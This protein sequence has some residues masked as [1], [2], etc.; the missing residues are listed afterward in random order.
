VDLRRL[1]AIARRSFLFVAA[2][3]LIAGGAAFLF[4]TTLTRVYEANTTLIVGQSLSTVSPDYNQLLVSQ[5]LSTTYASL[6]TTRPNLEAVITKLGLDE[7]TDQLGRSVNAEASL[8]ST[9][10]KIT[11]QDSDPARAA[12]VANALAQQLVTASPAVQGREA[13]FQASIEA[14]LKAT[15]DQID[16]TESQVA[17]L[18]S[19]TER[20]AAQEADLRGLESGL[21]SLRSTYAT[22]LSYASSNASNLLSVVEPAV[23]P[24]APVSPR[25]LLN[26]LLAA[27][28]GLFVGIIVIAVREYLDDSIKTPEDVLESAGLATLGQIMRMS[29]DRGRNGKDRV[30]ALLH[31]RSAVTESY[32]TLRANIEFASF[33]A[34]LNTLLI[35]SSSPLEGKTVTAANLAVVFAQ[36]GR[37]VLLVDADLRKPGVHLLFDLPNSHGLTTLLRTDRVDLHAVE[38]ATEQENLRILTTGPLP[39]NPVELLGSQRMRAILD[40]MKTAH[41]LVLFD[42]PPLQI[43]TDTAI[44][45]SIADGTVMVIGIGRGRRTAVR[46][47]RETLDRAGAHILGAVLNL[48]REPARSG[49]YGNYGD[50]GEHADGAD[51]RPAGLRTRPEDSAP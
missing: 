48:L 1:F 3:V 8:D 14:D 18:R 37:R 12:A 23:V 43:F 10:L 6:A 17:T 33:D 19:L 15:Q 5:R 47:G 24:A 22:L 45:S 49:S 13:A 27:L 46:H 7:T 16:A 20:T 38:Q 29:G 4:S 31:P 35:T 28:L 32:R 21:I 9:L 41:D 39:P 42:S 34:P 25:P 36:A 30:A 50:Y 51:Q 11:A 26:V 2:C 44:L 40:Q